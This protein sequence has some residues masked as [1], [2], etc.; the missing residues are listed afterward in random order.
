MAQY[1]ITLSV[2]PCAMEEILHRKNFVLRV[3]PENI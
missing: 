3:Y 2:R 1:M